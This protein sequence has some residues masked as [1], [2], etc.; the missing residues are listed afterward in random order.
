[1]KR[2]W[3]DNIEENGFFE[4]FEGA[5]V[6]FCY[7]FGS[8]PWYMGALMCNTLGIS[9]GEGIR[10]LDKDDMDFPTDE[11]SPQCWLVNTPGLFSLLLS[12]PRKEA[13]QFARWL[14]HDVL[15]QVI[16]TGKYDVPFEAA[17]WFYNIGFGVDEEEDGSVEK[18]IPAPE[19]KG[20]AEEAP[21]KK[22]EHKVLEFP[23]R[24]WKKRGKGPDADNR[25]K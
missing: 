14:T 11:N 25:E 2:E 4:D 12:S 23:S 7:V 24:G 10:R 22:A 6:D 13:K 16:K 8:Q 3:F 20:S 19:T 1:M 15:L 9:P 18:V 17:E 5:C 21:E